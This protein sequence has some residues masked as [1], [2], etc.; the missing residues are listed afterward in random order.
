MKLDLSTQCLEEFSHTLI[1][2][3]NFFFLKLNQKPE[4]KQT[5][6]PSSQNSE[7]YFKQA[8]TMLIKRLRLH[9]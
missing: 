3:Q 6:K 2:T 7:H 4:N 1:S 8:Q 9:S 5:K